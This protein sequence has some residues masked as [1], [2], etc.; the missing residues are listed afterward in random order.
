MLGKEIKT[1][2]SEPKPVGRYEVKFDATNLASEF[3]F[4]I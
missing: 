3:I 1:L 2:V 4:I